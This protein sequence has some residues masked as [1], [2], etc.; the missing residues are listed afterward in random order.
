MDNTDKLIAIAPM[1]SPYANITWQV[2][3]FCNFKCKYCNPGNWAGNN[4]KRNSTEDFNTIINNHF[5]TRSIFY[6]PQ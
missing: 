3:D 5:V 1:Y 2:S 4:P 6:L